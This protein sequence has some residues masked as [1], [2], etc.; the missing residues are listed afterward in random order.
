M[1]RY[2]FLD[3]PL[4]DTVVGCILVGS[5]AKIVKRNKERIISFDRE[6]TI[7]KFFKEHPNEQIM[8]YFKGI[9]NVSAEDLSDFFSI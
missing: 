1:S 7:K 5:P 3:K 4:D 2:A 9:E 8:Q 6:R